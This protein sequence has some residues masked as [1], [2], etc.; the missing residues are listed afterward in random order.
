MSFMLLISK[1]YRYTVCDHIVEKFHDKSTRMESKQNSGISC[2]AF[3]LLRYERVPIFLF[4]MIMKIQGRKTSHT[5]I[6]F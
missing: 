1:Y 6:S 4:S 2:F 3:Y 5:F